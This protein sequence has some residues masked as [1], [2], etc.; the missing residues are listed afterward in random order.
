[1]GCIRTASL[2]G[3]CLL[4]TCAY[5]QSVPA[6][7]QYSVSFK[8]VAGKLAVDHD[9]FCVAPALAKFEPEI[10]S[11][12]RQAIANIGPLSP[13]LLIDSAW[14]GFITVF[15]NWS[16]SD[17]ARLD[18]GT[19]F[20]SDLLFANLLKQTPDFGLIL[21]DEAIDPLDG[22]I[23]FSILPLFDS[24]TVPIELPAMLPARRKTRIPQLRKRLARLNGFL[25]SSADI[26]TAIAPLYANLGL[27]PQILVFPGNGAIQIVEGLRISSIVLPADQVPARDID[28]VLW[29][30][31]D[32][33]HFRKA[34]GKRIVY[35]GRDLGYTAGDEPYA[36]QYQIQAMQLLISPLGYSL[37]TQAS[38][39]T[40]PSQYVDLLVQ[41]NAKAHKKTRHA[42]AGFEYKPGQGFSA[43]GNISV[44]PFTLSV[45]GPSGLLGSGSYSA[46]YLGLSTTVNAGVSVERNRVLDGVK[47][48]EQSTG[49]SATFEWD[50]WRGVDGN[51]FRLQV[52][53]SHAMVFNQSLNT[54]KPGV[55]FVHN[56][57]A[58]EYPWRILI[59][60]RVLIALRFADCILTGNT[61]R[62]FDH[63][64]YDLSGR[65]E[66]AFG[67]VPIFELPSFGGADTVRGFRADDAIGR[68]LWADQSELWLPLPRWRTLKIATFG[69]LGGAYQTIGSRP[70][71]RAGIG[72]G[73]RL[74]LRVAVLKLDW[75]YG[76]GQA[77]T[78]GS[79]GKFYFNV[80]VPTQ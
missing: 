54:I 16:A 36:I 14:P 28:R 45:G 68:R 40:G 29:N 37:I 57:L 13:S 48:N 8:I 24:N 39:R 78:G 71:L 55:Q 51:T 31:L 30:L 25:W 10:R 41:S 5:A 77:A 6:R 7:G 80:A 18:L 3:L 60:P 59:S 26:R 43:I 65:F 75:A 23:S 32:T 49:D 58:S 74:D 53:P 73:L 35:C 56:A 44:S 17:P 72:T 12:V 61:H 15:E 2:V 33:G 69:D 38:T 76:F 19:L 21:N 67:S 20:S 79:R 34:R 62:A 4:V 22:A 46:E 9:A 64:E 11:I 70:G 66:N 27:T 50:P 47:V 42:G 1:M 63:W 52:D